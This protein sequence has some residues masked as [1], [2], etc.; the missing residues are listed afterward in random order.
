MREVLTAWV[1]EEIG[2]NIVK[3]FHVNPVTLESVQA[4][5]FVLL[6]PSTDNRHIFSYDAIIQIITNPKGV[7]T[8][9]L[10]EHKATWPLVIKVGHLLQ[11]IPA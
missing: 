1:G 6:D 3:P 8:G 10:F 4:D 2:C 11:Y 5:H 9:G 7:H